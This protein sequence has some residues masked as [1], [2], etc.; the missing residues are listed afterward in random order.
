MILLL[1]IFG[2]YNHHR[3]GKL[4]KQIKQL[5][6]QIKKQNKQQEDL[7][8]QLEQK[9]KEL[10][11]KEA[12]LEK[13]EEATYDDPDKPNVYLTFDDGP[14]TNTD[15]I[16]DTL[17]KY[18]VRATFFCIARD[19]EENAARYKRI[20]Q[21][22]HVLGMHSYTHVY[23]TVYADMASFQK[24]VT[25]LSDFLY[26][27]TGER[28]KYYRFPGGS[29]NTVSKVPMKKCIRFVTKEGLTY[30]DWNAQNDDATGT[31]YTASQLVSHAMTSVR[32]A[33][34]NVVLLMHDEQTKTATAESLPKLI[35]QLKT[36]GYDIL[37]ITDETPL[38]QH[39]SYDS[40]S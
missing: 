21:E 38:V 20:V 5:E 15:S 35:R 32:N 30:F 2:A 33:G 3:A 1:V 26:G 9:E 27:I 31:S 6:K 34:Q 10:K 18:N 28:P 23:K 25:D 4:Q 12:Q 11:E 22:G 8:D 40:V 29:S 13:A 17:G 7:E 37:P 19:G 14:S 36:A 16:L 39:I 24:D